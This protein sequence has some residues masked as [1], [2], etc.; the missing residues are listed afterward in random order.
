LKLCGS[1]AC[2]KEQKEIKIGSIALMK[3]Y[4][5]IWGL[6]GS[7]NFFA[8]KVAGEADLLRKSI[9]DRILRLSGVISRPCD[10]IS[11]VS[12]RILRESHCH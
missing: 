9:F 12:C 3:R 4:E 10:A 6:A 1:Q 11:R 7:A 8:S 2:R 5:T